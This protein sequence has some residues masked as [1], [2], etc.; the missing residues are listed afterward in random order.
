MRYLFITL[1]LVLVV[2]CNNS[3]ITQEE[4]SGLHNHMRGDCIA[5]CT[6]FKAEF[7]GN[8][9][10]KNKEQKIVV[11]RYADVGLPD[12][13]QCRV[14]SYHYDKE[15]KVLSQIYMSVSLGRKYCSLGQACFR[16]SSSTMGSQLERDGYTGK[17][18]MKQYRP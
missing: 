2:S 5:G 17:L 4:I 3:E 15:Y 13:K 8:G 16:C 7:I 1:L 14:F 11:L 18:D 12:Y 6:S 10:L 9:T